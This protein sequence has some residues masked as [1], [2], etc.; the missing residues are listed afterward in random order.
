MACRKKL[1]LK[2]AI[3]TSSI[4]P[5]LLSEVVWVCF[6]ILLFVIFFRLDYINKLSWLLTHRACLEIGTRLYRRAVFLF[7]VIKYGVFMID[8][9]THTYNH[10]HWVDWKR[11]YAC[12]LIGFI[13]VSFVCIFFTR[14][15]Q[16][17]GFWGG[18]WR[19]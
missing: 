15:I 16:F 18:L 14:N 17:V 6:C 5:S 8:T 4:M 7:Y 3:F 13:S 19:I 12:T 9:H 2:R 11:A 1:N 10:T